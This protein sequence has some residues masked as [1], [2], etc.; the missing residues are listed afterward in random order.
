MPSDDTNNNSN[1]KAFQNGR[2][3]I[4]AYLT[5][6]HLQKK[7]EKESF[8][9]SSMEKR[10]KRKKAQF[11]QVFSTETLVKAGNIIFFALEP[12][13]LGIAL[14][15]RAGL[16]FFAIICMLLLLK[17]FGS[18]VIFPHL[19]SHELLDAVS[20]L[21]QQR[22]C[23]F[24]SMISAHHLVKEERRKRIGIVGL[25]SESFCFFCFFGFLLPQSYE[26]TCILLGYF[27]SQKAFY[28]AMATVY[29][30]EK[31]LLA[32]LDSGYRSKTRFL[33]KRI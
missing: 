21:Q 4:T 9:Y 3:A 29:T 19:S 24:G 8:S 27:F 22:R 23:F 13:L 2:V 30:V 33:N 31:Y 11:R 1:N 5:I 17:L 28:T 18:G 32:N 15:G 10:P 16:S 20:L 26:M 14:Q 7:M 25:S 12:R 6:K